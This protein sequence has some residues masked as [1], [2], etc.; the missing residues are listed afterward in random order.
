MGGRVAAQLALVAGGGEQ[1]AVAG[2]HRA[3]R[4]VAVLGRRPGAL[5]GQFHQPLVGRRE[6][7]ALHRFGSMGEQ[8]LSRPSGVS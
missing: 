5:D 2:D 7:A 4:D 3:D 8:Q 1:L 6:I